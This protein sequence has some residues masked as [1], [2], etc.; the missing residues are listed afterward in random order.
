MI[1]VKGP[2]PRESGGYHISRFAGATALMPRQKA[3][4]PKVWLPIVC[5]KQEQDLRMSVMP[6][7]PG[8]TQSG[9]EKNAQVSPSVPDDA[10]SPLTLTEAVAAGTEPPGHEAARAAEL[11]REA[12]RSQVAQR[13]A[14]LADQ[15]ANRTK[16]A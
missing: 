13:I 7:K 6:Q 1:R 15:T 14:N 16:Q 11:K 9:S 8:E 2:S 3:L 10:D 4:A 12:T 5:A